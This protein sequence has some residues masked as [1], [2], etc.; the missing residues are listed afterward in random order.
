MTVL[1]S[2]ATDGVVQAADINQFK[3]MLEGASGYTSTYALT[4]TTGTNFV[5]KLGDAAGTNKMSI[6]DSAGVEVAYIDS[7]G[8]FHGSLSLGAGTLTFPTSASPTPTTEGLAYWDTDDNLLSIGDGAASK[9]LIPSPTTTAG[10]IE[11]ASGARAHSRLAIGTAG[12]VLTVNSG[13]TAPQWANS[14]GARGLFL[15]ATPRRKYAEFC[16]GS[17]NVDGDAGAGLHLPMQGLGFFQSGNQPPGSTYLAS[18][19][20]GGTT[21]KTSTTNSVYTGVLPISNVGTNTSILAPDRSPSMLV[22]VTHATSAASLAMYCVGFFSGVSTS[23]N[24]AYIFRAG[25]GNVTFRT[26]QGGSFTDYDLGAS[27]STTN[28]IIET[29]D[30]GTTWLLIDADSG[31]TLATHTTNVPTAATDLGYGVYIG[32][33]TTVDN[34]CTVRYIRVEADI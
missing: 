4:S 1:Y 12:Q 32:N 20:D 18:A 2:V 25:S 21:L 8:A 9:I 16:G 6:Q 31:S 10:D 11:Y 27:P 34:S 5:I 26:R 7:D 33:N 28:Y 22:S 19:A 23:P 3:S 15:A 30:A 14:Q 24:G 29:T 17:F 13:A